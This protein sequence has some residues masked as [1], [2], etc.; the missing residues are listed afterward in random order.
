MLFLCAGSLFAACNSNAD[1]VATITAQ[2]VDSSAATGVSYTT[3][4]S[5]LVTFVGS[6]PTDEHSGTF[7]LTEGNLL[8]NNDAISGGKFVININ[9]LSITDIKDDPKSKADLEGHLKAADF[10]DAAKWPSA[11]FEITSIEPYV[12]DSSS[13]IKDATNLV[14]GNLTLKDSTKNI[15]FPAKL[16]VTGNKLSASADF[17]IDRSQWGINYK[18]PNNPQDWVISKTVNIKLSISA[19]KK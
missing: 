18:G 4:S 1:K 3:D 17:N 2:S 19:T 5:S 12:A 7:S 13:K 8:V 14:K 6:K 15:A 10:F 9:S 11:Q 16:L